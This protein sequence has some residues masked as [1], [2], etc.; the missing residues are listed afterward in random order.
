MSSY[1]TKTYDQCG[2]WTGDFTGT[3]GAAIT[4]ELDAG[5]IRALNQILANNGITYKI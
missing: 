4:N 2:V 1:G 5:E 3:L